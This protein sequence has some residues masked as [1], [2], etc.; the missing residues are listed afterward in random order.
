VITFTDLCWINVALWHIWVVSLWQHMSYIPLT[1]ELSVCQMSYIPWTACKS[2]IS[3]SDNTQVISLGQYMSYLCVWRHMSYLCMWQHMSSLCV[4]RH[5]SY[6]CVWQHMI[7]LC[8]W[9]HINKGNNKITEQ[10]SKGK[11]K[12][13]KSTN[14]Q[15]QSTTGKLGKP[16]WPW[17]GTGISKETVGWIRFYSAK[18]PTSITVKR[19]QLSL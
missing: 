8:V 15:N 12:T 7:Y 4:W 18:P 14:R 2:D 16:Q 10:S 6:L 3:H 1:H 13:H 9:Q 11:G 19:F 5:M 17:L